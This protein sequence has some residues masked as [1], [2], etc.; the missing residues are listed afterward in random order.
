[1]NT[2]YAKYNIYHNGIDIHTSAGYIL[3][4]DCNKPED[5]LRTTPGSQC[6]LNA[7]AIDKPLEYANLYL[8]GT[9]QTWVD[10]EKSFFN[11]LKRQGLAS[12]FLIINNFH[13]L[14]IN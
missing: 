7:L 12:R 8:D 6:S 13:L 3:R 14:P 10:A 11:S 9:M 5:G 1:M 4:V 2:I